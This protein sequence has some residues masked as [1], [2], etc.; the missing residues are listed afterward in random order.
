MVHGSPWVYMHFHSTQMLAQ[1]RPP[2]VRGHPKMANFQPN[3]AA[4]KTSKFSPRGPMGGGGGQSWTPGD[5]T[6]DPQH[7]Q[8]GL[9]EKSR[10]FSDLR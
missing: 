4:L 8:H 5:K 6:R 9:A 10:F 2:I 7:G 1:G 3:C